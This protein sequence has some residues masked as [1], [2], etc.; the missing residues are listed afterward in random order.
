MRLVLPLLFSLLVIAGCGC[1]S[2]DECSVTNHCYIPKCS[3][4]KCLENPK[5]NCCGNSRQDKIED[6]QPGNKCTCPQDYGICDGST[7]KYLM[8]GCVND[9]CYVMIDPKKVTTASS[10]DI[11]KS[12]GVEFKVQS[13]WNQPFNLDKDTF[14]VKIQLANL[15][16]AIN[17]VRIRKLELYAQD[18]AKQLVLLSEKE[19]QKSLWQAGDFFEEELALDFASAKED[20][21]SSFK[22]VIS[23]EAVQESAEPQVS[24]VEVK[25]RHSK[26]SYADPE[27]PRQCPDDCDDSNDATADTCGQ[28]TNYFCSHIQIT[29]KCGNDAC[30]PSE[31]RCTCSDDCGPCSGSIGEYMEYGCVNKKC[32]SRLGSTLEPITRLDDR[33][34]DF[35]RMAIRYQY[36]K[37]FS[38]KTSNFAVELKLQEIKEGYSNI[39]LLSVAV[40]DGDQIVAESAGLSDTFNG[41]SDGASI[42]VPVTFHMADGEERQRSSAVK[43]WYTY[44]LQKTGS[45]STVHKTYTYDLG[46]IVYIN[47]EVEK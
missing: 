10:S 31:D 6:D 5:M 18:S 9:I 21:L 32:V 16:P 20:D 23:F 37:P 45:T 35:G 33:S 42:S 40:M 3:D 47:P 39:N 19:M 13:V 4:G 2:D 28:Q 8:Q 12:R 11:A 7:G 29:G 1:K 34:L 46:K 38:Y 30:D 43:I 22:L 44:D 26:F 17:Q 36:T 25:F 14:A 27:L 15:L 41:V 24:T